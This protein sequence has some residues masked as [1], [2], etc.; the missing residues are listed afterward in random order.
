MLRCY[1][2][3]LADLP[4]AGTEVAVRVTDDHT[5]GTLVTLGRREAPPAARLTPLTD[6]DAAQLIV[7]GR[8]GPSRPERPCW[9]T[10]CSGSR[11][12]PTTCPRSPSSS[13]AR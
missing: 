12:W 9:P 11:G 5:F 2:M 3:P 4:P 10:C 1:G 13:S 7:R 8:P 6:R